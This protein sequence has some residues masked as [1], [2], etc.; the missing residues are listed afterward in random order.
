MNDLDRQ[1][2]EAIKA[3][4]GQQA[5]HIAGQLGVDRKLV[6]SPLYGRLKG[7]VQQDKSY[8][9]YPKDSA[10]VERREDQ[11]PKQLNIEPGG[12]TDDLG[13]ESIAVVVGRLAGHPSTLPATLST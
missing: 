7:K 6:N 13:R 12:V 9:W 2:L 10:G 8:R 5:K 3:K 11:G 4:P 1:V